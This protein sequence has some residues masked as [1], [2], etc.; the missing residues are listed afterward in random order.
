MVVVVH[1]R[2][3]DGILS[4]D[5]ALSDRDGAIAPYLD[6]LAEPDAV[7][8]RRVVGHVHARAQYVQ[9]AAAFLCAAADG[10]RVQTGL[11]LRL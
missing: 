8:D 11:Q 2:V 1:L 6:V 10:Y 4:D 3:D 9:I 5:R 7:A